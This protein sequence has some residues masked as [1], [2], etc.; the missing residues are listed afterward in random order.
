MAADYIEISN[1]AACGRFFH[2]HAMPEALLVLSINHISAGYGNRQVLS[3]LSVQFATGRVTA[4]AGPNGCGKSTLLKAIMGFVALSE[5]E[6]LLDTE[7]VNMIGRRALARRVSYLPQEA[8]C[9]DYM[10]LGE[11]VELGGY[12]RRSLLGGPSDE[13]RKLYREVLEIVGLTPETS[14]PVSSLSGGQRQR[15]WVAMVLAQNT[16]MILMDEPV[17]HLDIKYQYTVLD[18]I[19]RLS[20]QYGKTVAVVLHDINLTAAFADDVVMLKNGKV[21]ASGSVETV[22][23]AEN[24]QTV[25]DIPADIFSH[26]NRL[27][28][29]PY[30]S[31]GSMLIAD[32]RCEQ[33]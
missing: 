33:V 6:I 15:A 7:P 18:L 22:I 28:C 4:L 19:R 14:R 29:Q 16:D 21:L 8:H 23:T 1:S 5:G 32:K 27:V 30:P 26:K 2:P 11:L 25:F 24:M 12:A 20:H 9:P 13:E 31:E 3:D 10:T 17:N